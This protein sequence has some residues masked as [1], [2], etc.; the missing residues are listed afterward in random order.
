MTLNWL[1]QVVDKYKLPKDAKIRAFTDWECS[2]VP[3]GAV[4]YNKA[5]NTVILA[6]DKLTRPREEGYELVSFEKESK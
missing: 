5:E 1:D 2:S 6:P 4:W 3:L